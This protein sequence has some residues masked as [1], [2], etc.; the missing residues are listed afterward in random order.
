MVAIQDQRANGDAS[1]RRHGDSGATSSTA[2]VTF[3]SR[4][5]DDSYNIER[6]EG[7]TGTFAQVGTVSGTGH[8]GRR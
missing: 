1:P 4:A 8:A 5:G 2:T 3:T 6:A 7:A